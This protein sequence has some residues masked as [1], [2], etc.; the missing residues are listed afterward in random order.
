MRAWLVVLAGCGRIGFD[1]ICPAP[2]GHDEDGDGIDDACDVCPQIADPDQLDSDGDGVGD[3]CDP[4]T[5][6]PID[7]IAF[8]DP[9]TIQLPQW[10]FVSSVTY[11]DDFI[12]VDQTAGDGFSARL[13]ITPSRDTFW[14]GGH[15]GLDGSKPR[16]L[17]VQEFVGTAN[18]CELYDAGAGNNEVA[19][20]ET[21]DSVMYTDV[22]A[23]AIV[24]PLGDGDATLT[25]QID[26][27]NNGCTTSWKGQPFAVSGA[28]PT[29]AADQVAIFVIGASVQINYFLHIHSD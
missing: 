14:I 25:F 19:L 5:T 13:A 12:T 3:P 29:I 16:E 2:S 20:V 6:D 22:M 21:A 15:V 7:H 1:P 18:Y 9:F 27:P 24:G 17:S 28:L 11:G 4:H 23:Q 8:F 26:P 10:T